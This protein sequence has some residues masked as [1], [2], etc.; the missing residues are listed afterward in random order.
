MDSGKHMT[1][2]QQTAE[3]LGIVVEAAS[4]CEQVTEECV[5]FVVVKLRDLSFRQM[6]KVQLRS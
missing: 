4:C 6:N 1:E 3:R 2:A 5:D